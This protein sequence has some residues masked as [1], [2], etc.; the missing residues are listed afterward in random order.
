MTRPVKPTPWEIGKR[1]RRFR[2]LR[3]LT[4]E[5]L[6]VA[7]GVSKSYVCQCENGRRNF[8]RRELLDNFAEVLGCSVADLTG[9]R[10]RPV[11]RCTAATLAV[12]PRIS[13]ALHDASLD[14]V[15]EAAARP[16]EM[17]ADLAQ[18][19]NRHTAH[20]RYSQAAQGLGSLLRE[21]HAAAAAGDADTRRRALPAVAEACLAACAVA[22]T[23][24]NADVAVLAARRAVEAGTRAADPALHGFATV[25]LSAA[26]D[27]A[28]ARWAAAQAA[29]AG[30]R[31]LE[32]Q[33]YPASRDTAPAQAAGM[34]HL[35]LAHIAARDR[36]ADEAG[37]HLQHA[38]ALAERT[39][40]Q[41]HL[42]SGFGPA[43]VSVWTLAVAVESGEGPDRAEELDRQSRHL[44]RLLAPDRRAA[45]HFLLARAYAQA[46]GARDAKALYHLDRADHIAPQRIRNDPDAQPL[47]AELDRRSRT[48]PHLLVSLGNRLSRT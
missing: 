28:G 12:L 26:L 31:A 43:A 14:S 32:A 42:W 48:K 25:S 22:A 45:F 33:V 34:L 15:A 36:R 40:E 38:R 46:K 18:Q 16:V 37:R 24:G 21:L 30:L 20:G 2:T 47:W 1:I 3:Q 6:A 39:G 7:L 41:N 19:A 11:D 10:P 29:Q 4:Q 35:S 23:L 17:L 8:N 27:R 9:Q 44:D 5:E 13:L